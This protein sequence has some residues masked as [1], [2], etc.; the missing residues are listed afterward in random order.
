MVAAERI[1]VNRI[2]LVLPLLAAPAGAEEIALRAG[3]ILTITSEP[4]QD[5]VVLIEDGKIRSVGRDVIVPDGARVIDA[6]DSFVVPGLVDA[7]SSFYL[8]ESELRSPGSGAPELTVVD[9]LDPFVDGHEEVL[10]QGVTAIYVAPPGSGVFAGQ[11]A[12][13]KMNG[14]NTPKD[15]VLKADVAV[16]GSIGV[17]SGNESSSLSRLDDYAN[18]R[19]ML[20][21]TQAY[22]E[23]QTLYEQELAKYERSNDDKQ[24]EDGDKPSDNKQKEKPKKPA[25]PK[26]N[27]TQETLKRVLEKEIPLQI[28]AHRVSDILSALRLADEFNFFLI[29]DRCTEGY[30]IAGEIARRK[31]PVIVGPVST[32]FIDMPQLQYRSHSARNAAILADSG[33]QTAIGV[34]GRDGVSSKFA[35]LAA[36]M[37]TASGMDKDMALRAITLTPAEILGVADRIGSLDAGKDADVVILTGHPFETS[38]RVEMVLIDGKTVYER[39]ATP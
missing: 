39:K 38:S 13:L 28:E 2:L 26:P 11:G 34:S 22:I 6:K 8:L 4:I 33:V 19:E 24:S 35:S 17:P 20:I 25:K 14:A 23:R 29:L 16:K 10:A 31:V 37:A 18:L 15:L 1:H 21:A 5:G 9:A 36:A 32:S 27:P 12:V 30:R 3:T 7:Q